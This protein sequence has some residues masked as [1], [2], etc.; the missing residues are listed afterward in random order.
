PRGRRPLGPGA[1]P[2]RGGGTGRPPD[3]RRGGPG[4]P[5]ARQGRRA[6]AGPSGSSPQRR[7]QRWP[8][9]PSWAWAPGGSDDSRGAPPT[10]AGGP[11]GRAPGRGRGSWPTPPPGPPP[12]PPA[13]LRPRP[14]ASPPVAFH[15]ASILVEIRGRLNADAGQLWRQLAARLTG[16]IQP[17]ARIPEARHDVGVLVETLVHRREKDGHVGVLPPQPLDPLGGRDEGHEADG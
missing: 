11:G 5:E 12:R 15:A 6:R 10:P 7:R 13:P 1:W 8:R 16:A 17:V 9:R 14:Q 3:P 2:R 4:R